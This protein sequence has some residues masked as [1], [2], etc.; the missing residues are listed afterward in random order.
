MRFLFYALIKSGTYS[1]RLVCRIPPTG[2]AWGTFFRTIDVPRRQIESHIR[3]HSN[4][5]PPTDPRS[6][7][8]CLGKVWRVKDNR[9]R[10]GWLKSESVVEIIAKNLSLKLNG[11]FYY[12]HNYHDVAVNILLHLRPG[13]NTPVIFLTA[14]P[15]LCNVALFENDVPHVQ[16]AELPQKRFRFGKP[17]PQ[18]ILLLSDNEGS[19]GWV[20]RSWFCKLFLIILQICDNKR[21]L[22]CTT[23]PWAK[24]MPLSRRIPSTNMRQEPYSLSQVTHKKCQ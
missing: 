16:Q 24:R 8:C 15:Q 9:D 23:A 4:T 18:A 17:T 14:V 1:Y 20:R 13:Y 10:T 2:R 19:I 11:S 21:A 12:S 6:R 5:P 22:P 3:C 7:W